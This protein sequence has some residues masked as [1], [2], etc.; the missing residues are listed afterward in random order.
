MEERAAEQ[1]LNSLV[2]EMDE[3]ASA[4]QGQGTL[5]IAGEDGLAAVAVMEACIKSFETEVPIYI[6]DLI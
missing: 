2:E 3:F 4:I 1:R 6:K 5:E